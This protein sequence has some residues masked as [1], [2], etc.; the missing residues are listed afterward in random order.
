MNHLC[1]A[2]NGIPLTPLAIYISKNLSN[3]GREKFENKLLFIGK[4]PQQIKEWFE[5]C[6]YSGNHASR[7]LIN[8]KTHKVIDQSTP[9]VTR[10]LQ[11]TEAIPH[12]N[13]LKK[14]SQKM[15][16]LINLEFFQVCLI[17][18]DDN[19]LLFYFKFQTFSAGILKIDA[20]HLRSQTEMQSESR[21]RNSTFNLGR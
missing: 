20:I 5:F 10:Y 4:T 9:L 8:S 14:S 6:S 16:T 18:L 15:K 11:L 1:E 2:Q 7:T 13:S 12:G 21:N 17:F 19:F 3:K